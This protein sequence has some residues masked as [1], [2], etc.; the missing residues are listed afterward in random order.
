MPTGLFT[1]DSWWILERSLDASALR[2][3][4]T[5]NNIANADTPQFKASSVEFE[6]QLRKSLASV[7]PQGVFP[8]ARRIS[9]PATGA[10]ANVRP[11]VVER[12]GFTARNDGNN[13]DVEFEM[14]ALAENDLFYQALSRSLSD[15][16]TRLRTAI[17]GRG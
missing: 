3:R 8:A 4:V 7:A 11:S 1:N 17:E 9:Y 15:G 13:V 16:F 2:Q 6:A 14:T 10:P 5:A 12:T